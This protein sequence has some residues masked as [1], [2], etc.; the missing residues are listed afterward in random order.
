[1][2][3]CYFEKRKYENTFDFISRSKQ[4]ERKFP[5]NRSIVKL[6]AV[7]T[8]LHYGLGFDSD[9]VLVISYKSCL[10]YKVLEA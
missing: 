3:M 1:M 7:D 8:N 2:F 10:V 5:P 4:I 9:F 6:L